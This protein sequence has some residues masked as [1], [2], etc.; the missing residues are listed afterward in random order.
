MPAGHVGIALNITGGTGNPDQIF[1]E[2]VTGN[3]FTVLGARPQIGRG[4]LPDRRKTEETAGAKLVTVLG[5]GEWQKRCGGDPSIVGRTIRIERG[6]L[7]GR[8]R[9]C[10]RD[11]R[12]PMR[13]V[14]RRC[15]CQP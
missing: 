8:R 15:G 3:Y 14:R 1:G 2:L 5:C 7:H 13:S 11:S 6:G 10:R 4:F 12:G 9:D